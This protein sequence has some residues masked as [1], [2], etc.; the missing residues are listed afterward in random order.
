[1]NCEVRPLVLIFYSTF[2][3]YYNWFPES[4]KICSLPS[5]LDLSKNGWVLLVHRTQSSLIVALIQNSF[6]EVL[7][8]LHVLI[9]FSLIVI[10]LYLFKDKFFVFGNFQAVEFKV[11]IEIIYWIACR[12]VVDEMQLFHIGMCKG[13]INCNSFGRVKS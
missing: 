3:T 6:R 1:M 7:L 10:Q 4:E 11:K 9:N 13:L 5:I 2:P 12:F 8:I